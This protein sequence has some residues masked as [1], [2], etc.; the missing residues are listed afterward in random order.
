[1][2]PFGFG[3]ER[4][5]YRWAAAESDRYVIAGVVAHRHLNA[6]QAQGCGVRDDRFGIAPNSDAASTFRPPAPAA[7]AA[8]IAGMMA[9]ALT[10]RCLRLRGGSLGIKAV[11]RVP[12][13]LPARAYGRSGPRTP[14]DRRQRCVAMLAGVAAR[15]QLAC[16][17]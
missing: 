17:R 4:F 7:F 10:G 13:A 11:G 14:E 12:A 8:S 6:G 5:V 9:S 15:E 1:M 2:L 3:R 16:A